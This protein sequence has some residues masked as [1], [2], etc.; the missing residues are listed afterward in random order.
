MEHFSTFQLD[1][2]NESAHEGALV[3]LTSPADLPSNTVCRARIRC[4]DGVQEQQAYYPLLN[5][6][7]R[8]TNDPHVNE[9]MDSRA[10]SWL[11]PL[12]SLNEAE[13]Q[14]WA[15]ERTNVIRPGMLREV[16]ELLD[17]LTREFSTPP[18]PRRPPLGRFLYHACISPPQ[19][20]PV[21]SGRISLSDF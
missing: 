18:Q 10:P 5:A 12:P 4:V 9:A 11:L 20:A 8:L 7:G 16:G 2:V 1:T 14:P 17:S 6:L 21:N 13:R 19:K 15:I 3:A